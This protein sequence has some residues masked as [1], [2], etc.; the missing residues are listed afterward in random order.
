MIQSALERE[1]AEKIKL[2]LIISVG[3]LLFFCGPLS[4]DFTT[5]GEAREAMVAQSMLSSGSYTLGV[6]YNEAVPSKPPFLHWAMCAAAKIVGGLNESAAR[7]P[8]GILSL[9][10][11]AIFFR[12]VSRVSGSDTGFLG[13]AMLLTSVE[14]YRSS[15]EAR[16]DM[17]LAALIAIGFLAL[18]VWE[19]NEFEGNPFAAQI[20]F[21]L[22]SLAKGPVSIVL[23]GAVFAAYLLAQRRELSKVILASL[24]A[25][26]PAGLF[27]G[28]WY[29]LAVSQGGDRFIDKVYA[30][31]V[32]R[33]AGTMEDDPHKHSALYLF[34]TLLLG[35][36]PWTIILGP[37]LA[38]RISGFRSRIME[39]FKSG[40]SDGKFQ[41]FS[42]LVLVGFLVFYSIPSSKRSVYLL[43]AYPFASFLLART[44]SAR[45]ALQDRVFGR[46]VRVFS[47]AA[48]L[49]GL[50]LA[51]VIAGKIPLGLFPLKP[52][53]VAQAEFA[54]NGLKSAYLSAA[55]ILKASALLPIALAI[56][57]A[58]YPRIRYPLNMEGAQ[59]L[60]L[61][62]SFYLSIGAFVLPKTAELLSPKSFAASIVR[63]AP[64]DKKIYSYGNEFYALGFYTGRMIYRAEDAGQKLDGYVVL[65]EKNVSKFEAF[66]KGRALFVRILRSDGPVFEPDEALVLGRVAPL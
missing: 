20:A 46:T 4:R 66:A 31:N 5:R 47:F 24:Q 56:I 57:V 36:L 60:F 50:A 43:P 32:A 15:I 40:N 27:Y 35:F 61:V 12:V 33:F 16:V 11:L 44:W 19:E 54:A 2:L 18:F 52:E 26:V 42:W 6:G 63:E 55:P 17:S 37:M 9:I 38:R 39:L 3:A 21:G 48:A 29:G 25:F 30:E 23:P 7:L 62:S 28:A 51:L 65:Y 8:S 58:I 22:A 13:A 41:L 1:M 34:G 49:A 45:S 53:I 64:A 10:L 59:V 14:W